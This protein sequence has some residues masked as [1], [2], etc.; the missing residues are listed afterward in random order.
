[1]GTI[2]LAN[3]MVSGETF[4]PIKCIVRFAF[5]SMVFCLFGG[6]KYAKK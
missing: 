5:L 3:Y 4:I 1:V 6:L 2:S